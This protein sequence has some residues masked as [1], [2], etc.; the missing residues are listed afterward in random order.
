M[1][2]TIRLDKRYWR[3]QLYLWSEGLKGN[4]T[5]KWKLIKT[6]IYGVRSSGNLAEYGLR[7]T[8]GLCKDLF[9]RAFSVVTQYTYIDD[10][11]SGTE[12]LEETLS[13]T[14]ELEASVLKGGFR[15][16]GFTIS[17]DNPSENLSSDGVS[18]VVAGLRWFPEGDF[19]KLNIS[20]L[21]FNKKLRGLK[22]S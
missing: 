21:N 8:V 16:K 7:Q 4:S 3:Y 18:V 19:F 12:S 11:L 14:D 1:Y 9:P 10:M 13:L 15:L 2:N 6:F 20:E 5:P 17:G 22:I